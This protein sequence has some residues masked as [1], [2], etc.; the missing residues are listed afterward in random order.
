MI[1]L[2]WATLTGSVPW[3]TLG[4]LSPRGLWLTGGQRWEALPLLDWE[5]FLMLWGVRLV[6]LG[7]EMIR[8]LVTPWQTLPCS[9]P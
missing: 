6:T 8:D 5:H 7:Q 9:E 3:V 2:P 4:W 1:L